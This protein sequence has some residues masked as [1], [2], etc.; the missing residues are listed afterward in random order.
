MYDDYLPNYSS[1]LAGKYC[2]KCSL[3]EKAMLTPY[4][5]NILKQGW[6]ISFT[7]YDDNSNHMVVFELGPR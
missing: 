3:R 1:V 5:S 2:S 6:K 4:K 7:L